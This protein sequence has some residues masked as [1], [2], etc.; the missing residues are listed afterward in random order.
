MA[1]QYPDSDT[2]TEG[3]EFKHLQVPIHCHDELDSTMDEAWRLAREN[4]KKRSLGQVIV[5]DRQTEGRGRHGRNWF[6]PGDVG[7]WVSVLLK[8][9]LPGHHLFPHLTVIA[10]LSV[11]HAVRE[12]TDSDPRI[13]WPNDV[14]YG[15][16]EKDP[17]SVQKFAGVLVETKQLG[18]QKRPRA[19]VGCGINVNMPQEKFPEEIRNEATSIRAQTGRQLDRNKLLKAYLQYL[20]KKLSQLYSHRHAEID[21][22]WSRFSAVINRRV[23]IRSDE[24]LLT[25]TVQDVSLEKGLTLRMDEGG[26]RIFE[27]SHVEELRIVPVKKT[28]PSS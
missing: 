6:S 3:I 24:R 28:E 15:H 19:V 23:K 25:G 18:N 11:V 2:I 10:S 20:D 9:K 16:P 22:E 5:A 14:V 4:D 21:D 1:D 27:P 17:G 13:R 12:E 8:P 26:Y 7:I